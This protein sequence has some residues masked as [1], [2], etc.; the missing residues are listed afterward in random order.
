MKSSYV[1]GLYWYVLL[2]TY[3]DRY[4]GWLIIG[5]WN[6]VKLC[7]NKQG[8]WK[9][10]VTFQ[11]WNI[12]MVKKMSIPVCFWIRHFFYFKIKWQMGGCRC[13]GWFW[14]TKYFYPFYPFFF[15]IHYNETVTWLKRCF[16][17]MCSTLSFKHGCIHIDMYT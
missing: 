5:I 15:I 17:Q 1:M 14:F 8:Y 3:N 9:N 6:V 13:T 10:E 11:K 7:K 12:F 2:E 16:D 4:G